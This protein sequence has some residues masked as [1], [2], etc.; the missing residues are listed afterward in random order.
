[1]VKVLLKDADFEVLEITQRVSQMKVNV[2]VVRYVV[3]VQDQN[4]Y[5]QGIDFMNVRKMIV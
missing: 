5:L 2:L 3:I 1:M 4:D